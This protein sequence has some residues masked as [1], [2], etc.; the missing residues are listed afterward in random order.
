[1]FTTKSYLLSMKCSNDGDTTYLEGSGDPV[2]V[3]TDHR[4]LQYF[5]M[6]KILMHQQ[7]RWSEY[8]STFNLVIHFHPGK[9]GTKPD[10]LTR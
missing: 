3:V 2:D 1:M 9:L 7:A 6:T 8:L 4:N 10:T 5:S